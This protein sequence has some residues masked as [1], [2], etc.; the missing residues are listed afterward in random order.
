MIPL[1]RSPL[2]YILH[3]HTQNS[4]KHLWEL[5]KM[6]TDGIWKE[7]A[8]VHFIRAEQGEKERASKSSI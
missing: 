8:A 2:T 4:G 6:R 1:W 5:A 3:Q 7:R